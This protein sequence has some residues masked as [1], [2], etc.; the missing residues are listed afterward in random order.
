V[1]TAAGAPWSRVLFVY[2]KSRSLVKSFFT[3]LLTTNVC[4][5]FPSIQSCLTV[6]SGS[7]E[8]IS[9]GDFYYDGGECEVSTANMGLD[10][11]HFDEDGELC[12]DLTRCTFSPE[13]IAHGASLQE[14]RCMRSLSGLAS[15]A[16]SAPFA[17]LAK[18]KSILCPISVSNHYSDSTHHVHVFGV[19]NPESEH[20]VSAIF[21]NVEGLSHVRWLM[22]VVDVPR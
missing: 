7:T 22:F 1:F 8:L 6:Y 17:A 20:S 10:A 19:E 11:S 9:S 16:L 12:F 2:P 21:C 4:D 15:A 18:P 14:P 3:R 5:F 13:L